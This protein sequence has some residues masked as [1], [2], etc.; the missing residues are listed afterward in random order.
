M[1]LV[2]NYLADPFI[3]LNFP[4]KMEAAHRAFHWKMQ[5]DT[6]INGR[7]SPIHCLS[8]CDF[9]NARHALLFSLKCSFSSIPVVLLCNSYLVTGVRGERSHLPSHCCHHNFHFHS[10]LSLTKCFPRNNTVRHLEWIFL[11]SF[12]KW[13]HR[14]GKW[15]V[16]SYISGPNWTQTQVSI[17]KF[18]ALGKAMWY[19]K[20]S[21][22]GSS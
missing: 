20:W 8:Y 6:W 13:G 10:H 12:Y 18:G 9:Q 5:M 14:L 11:S 2:S 21:Q 3:C 1:L 22:T 16:Q 4:S 15:L 19:G 17:S 7:G